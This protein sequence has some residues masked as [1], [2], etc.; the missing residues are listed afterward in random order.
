[1]DKIKIVKFVATLIVGSGTTTIASSII[2]N[3]VAPANLLQQITVGGASVVIGSMAA[4]ATKAHTETQIDAV[5]AAFE[6][7]KN[8]PAEFPAPA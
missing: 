2:K 6:N 3:N 5:V 7:F 4:T 8:K 1:M